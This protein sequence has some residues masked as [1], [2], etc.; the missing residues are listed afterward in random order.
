MSMKRMNSITYRITGL[1]FLLVGCSVFILIYLVNQQMTGLFHQYLMSHNM[2]MMHVNVMPDHS[3]STVMG[4]P[5]QVFLASV[6][7]SL[8]WVGLGILLI[9]LAASYALARSITVPLLK[10]SSAVGEIEQGNFGKKVEVESKDEIGELA[11]LF[12]R[13]SAA[14]ALNNSM[15][16]RLFA[17]ITHELKTPLAVIHGHLE[18]M[19]EGVIDMNKEQIASVLEETIHLNRLIKDLKDLSLAEAGQLMLER[20]P[21]DINQLISRV[22]YMLEPLAEEKSIHI[23]QYLQVIPEF[24]MDQ[25]RINQILYNLLTNAL[26]Y[27]PTQGTIH[28]FTEVAGQEWVKIGIGDSGPGIAAED[29]PYV[30]DHFYRADKSRNRKSGGTG[31]GLAIVKQLVELHGG[32]VE[33]ESTLGQGSIFYVYLPLHF[34]DKLAG[35]IV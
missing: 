33:V 13:M 25:S 16:Q 10:L 3:I 26:R 12:N 22:I 4:L 34:A 35:N 23:K 11:V 8:I 7:Q 24:L 1:M 21:T 19:L 9:G 2:G 27:T 20:S 32:K 28:V 29:L 14:L 30:F 17:D 15:R 5:E 31:I 18:G 6:H